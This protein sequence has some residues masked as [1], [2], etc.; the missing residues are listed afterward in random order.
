MAIIWRT[1][2]NSHQLL[3]LSADELQQ[4]INTAAAEAIRPVQHHRPAELG[5]FYCALEQERLARLLNEWLEQ[6]KTRVPFSVIA[7]EE[8]HSVNFAGLNLQLRIDR[9]D[10]L[11]NGELLL[12]DY[13]TGSPKLKS[14]L[15]KRPDE[16]QLPLYAVSHH[17]PVAAIAFA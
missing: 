10:Q 15:G 3:A 16:P 2:G 9:I 14:W 1:L 6:E 17:T 13:K 7:I 11:E 12:I 8:K 5:S 4:L